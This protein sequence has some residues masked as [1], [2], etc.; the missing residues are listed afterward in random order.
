VR[1]DTNL[2]KKFAAEGID[3]R[4]YGS[5][6]GV[7]DT[8]TKVE[9]RRVLR[10]HS[11]SGRENNS[12]FHNRRGEGFDDISG[13]SGLDS[14]ADGRAFAYFDYDHDGRTDVVLTNSNS[15]Q[16]QLFRNEISTAGNSVSVRLVG[17][18]TGSSPSEEWSPRDGYGA[19]VLVEVGAGKLLRE[20]R[21]GD[22]FA[23]QNSRVLTIGIGRNKGVDK[24]S[25]VWPSRKRS[26]FGAL[27]AG[28]LATVYENAAEAEA[29]TGGVKIDPADF[30][31]TAAPAPAIAELKLPIEADLAVVVTMATWCPVCRGEIPRLA[32]L[33][34]ATAGRM[35]FYGLPI[36]PDDSVEKLAQYQEDVSPPYEIL[37][38]ITA[39][40]RE[41]VGQLLETRFGERP[42]P[43]TLIIDRA[44]RVLLARKGTPTLS[45]LRRIFGE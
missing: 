40:Q 10:S 4:Q 7:L 6:P 30:P 12:V 20:L 14:I 31:L 11:F 9:G 16:L 23:A 41:A 21:C 8:N 15:P 43:A 24:L 37:S 29:A 2:N 25:V 36:D 18:N 45:Q 39:A 34:S 27:A 1:S 17:G 13:I 44:G 32:R 19:R 3:T 33:G 38:S 42:L 35:A 26:D 28:H 5:M 22:G